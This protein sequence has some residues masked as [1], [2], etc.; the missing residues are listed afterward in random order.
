M[1]FRQKVEQKV[2]DISSALDTLK[3][4]RIDLEQPAEDL[5]LG[6]EEGAGEM[7]LTVNASKNLFGS[8]SQKYSKTAKV[9]TLNA[10]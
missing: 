1:T 7:K 3:S 8:E 4:P 5:E 10:R 9:S 6:E 2:P